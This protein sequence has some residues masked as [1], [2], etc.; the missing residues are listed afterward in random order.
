MRPLYG[1]SEQ[2]AAFVAAFGQRVD[3]GEC[4]AIGFLSDAGTLEAGAV[5]HDWNPEKEAIEM[6]FASLNPRWVSRSTAMLIFGY[7]FAQLG[8][9]VVYGKTEEPII[10]RIF[11]AL[12]GDG[13]AIPGLWTIVTL[14]AEQWSKCKE[15]R[16]IH[17]RT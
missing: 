10:V 17:A 11:K 7:P 4:Q 6:S 1:C 9:R 14:T 15:A 16:L 3:F 8:C 12:G 5:Y 13:Y 2:V